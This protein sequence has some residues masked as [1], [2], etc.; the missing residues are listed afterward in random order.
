MARPGQAIA[1]TLSRILLIFSRTREQR[2]GPCRC[3][4]KTKGVKE[5]LNRTEKDD[6]WKSPGNNRA[7]LNCRVIYESMEKGMSR[8]E[9]KTRRLH[10]VVLFVWF[11]ENPSCDPI[12]GVVRRHPNVGEPDGRPETQ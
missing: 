4:L 1:T 8:V 3:L 10:W 12:V 6:P 5:S 2:W 9:A 11:R 7:Y